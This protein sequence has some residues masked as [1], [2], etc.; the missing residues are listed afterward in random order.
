MRPKHPYGEYGVNKLAVEQYLTGDQD[1]VRASVV[2]P[3]H[4]SGPGWLPIGP[5]GNLDP[6]AIDSL[7][8]DGSC[9]ATRPRRRDHPSRAA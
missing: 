4:I 3:G 8:A 2:H 9:P 7:R 1:R 6:G 5:A